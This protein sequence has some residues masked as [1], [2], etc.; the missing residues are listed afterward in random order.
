MHSLDRQS[1]HNNRRSNRRND[2]EDERIRNDRLEYGGTTQEGLGGREA[3]DDLLR[4]RKQ[5]QQRRV[6]MRHRR[7]R[8][9]CNASGR[10]TS[11]NAHEC[12]VDGRHQQSRLDALGNRRQHR[13]GLRPR[14]VNELQ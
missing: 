9:R 13:I 14:A 1:T 5:R 8:R 7:C 11:D 6:A 3:I 2:P 4:K 10:R 12:G